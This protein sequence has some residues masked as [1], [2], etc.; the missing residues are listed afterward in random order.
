MVE[1]ENEAAAER[2]KLLSENRELQ[3][4]LEKL[5]NEFETGVD[6]LKRDFDLEKGRLL[7]ENES[8]QGEKLVYIESY[9]N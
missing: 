9:S 8:A 2:E 1:L 3:L 4:V 6:E 7:L 5:R